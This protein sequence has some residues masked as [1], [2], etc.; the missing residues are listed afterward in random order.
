M[1]EDGEGV[2]PFSTFQQ[3]DLRVGR[4]ETA[5]PVEGADRLLKLQVNMGDGT[6]QLVAGIALQYAPDALVGKQV[7]VV[8]NLEPATIRG[9]V[10]EGMVLAASGE[11]CLSLVGPDSDVP[12]GTAVH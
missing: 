5:E 1:A 10:S 11:G 6:R 3:L 2:I 7:V 12:E 8:A 9:V 4:I